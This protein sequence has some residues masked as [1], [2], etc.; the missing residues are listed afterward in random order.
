MFRY[1]PISGPEAVL[2]RTNYRD[3]APIQATAPSPDLQNR[4]A[5]GASEFVMNLLRRTMILGMLIV[6]SLFGATPAVPTVRAHGVEEDEHHEHHV[7]RVYY[8][9]GPHS[10]W[11]RYGRYHYRHQAEQARNSLHNHGYEAF[12]R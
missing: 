7:Y 1:D 8:R 12:I 5:S 10:P 4:D 9:E 3:C 11:I 6:L 2:M